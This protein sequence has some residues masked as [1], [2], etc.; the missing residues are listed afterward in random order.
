[1]RPPYPCIALS[2]V[3]SLSIPVIMLSCWYALF[4]SLG[5]VECYI[6]NGSTS[7]FDDCEVVCNAGVVVRVLV[8]V[9]MPKIILVCLL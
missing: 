6:L 4:L 5:M 9:M 2:M 7:C 8:S 1:M 3:L